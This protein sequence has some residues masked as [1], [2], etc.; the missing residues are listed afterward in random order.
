MNYQVEFKAWLVEEDRGEKTIQT[1]LSVLQMFVKWYEQTEGDDF[2]L[3]RVTPLHIHDYRSYLAN[4]LEQ[5]PATINKAIATLKTFFTWAV[6]A[7]HIGNSPAAKVKMKR[8]QKSQTPKWLTDNEKNRLEVV[9]ETEK[10]EFKKARDRAIIFTMM[11]AGLRIEE[12]SDLKLNHLD[13][14]QATVTVYNGKGGKFRV[15]P[16]NNDLKKALKNWLDFRTNSTKPAHQDSSYVF[17][18][19]RSGK[20]AE[21]ALNHMFDVYLERC[22]LLERSADGAKLEGQHSCHSLRHTFCKD[23]ANK[24]IPI[25]QIKELAGHDSIQTTAIYIQSSGHDLR[26]AVNRI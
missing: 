8:V 7:K 25:E 1:Y 12:V 9:L 10:N 21:R 18:S 20:L 17:V 26:K 16:M 19:E 23:L 2:N 4:N 24:G 3:K 5:K 22:G 11:K 13:M 14:R 6:E 15:V